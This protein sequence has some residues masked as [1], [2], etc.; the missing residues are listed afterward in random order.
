MVRF[1][2]PLIAALA[3]APISAQA[4]DVGVAAAVNQDAQAVVPGSGAKTIQLGDNVV[5]NQRIDT[6]AAGLVQI[7]LADGTAFTVGPNS[8]MTIDAFVYD[9]AANTASVAASV[10][11]GFVRFIGG[12]TSK[13]EGGVTIDTPIGT[14]GIRGAVADISLGGD[15]TDLPPHIS[16]LF[17]DQITLRPPG[18]DMQS[19][20]EAGYSIVVDGGKAS[21]Q[22]TP[23]EFVA[24]MQQVLAPKPGMSGGAAAGPTNQSA[25]R[26]GLAAS[27]SGFGTPGA[28]QSIRG[29]VGTYGDFDA[30]AAWVE[31][32]NLYGDLK[33]FF[34]SNPGY[35]D[36]DATPE[37]P[38]FMFAPVRVLTAQTYLDHNNNVVQAG[39]G[40]VA[41]RPGDEG[42]FYYGFN[43]GDGLIQFE[44]G[45]VISVP[46]KDDQ[47]YGTY[48]VTGPYAGVLHIGQNEFRA[49]LLQ[50]SGG[51]P[52]YALTGYSADAAAVLP[53]A[54]IW[55][56]RLS[57]DP[58]APIL[59]PDGVA[60]P[61]ADGLRLAQFSSG[62]VTAG[63]LFIAGTPGASD[64]AI[65]RGLQAWLAI[66]GTGVG[67]ISAINLTIGAVRDDNGPHFSG[68]RTGSERVSNGTQAMVSGDVS[69]QPSGEN[70]GGF[71]GA[72][73]ANIVIGTNNASD[74]GFGLPPGEFGTIHVGNRTEI[75]SGPA[76]Q[77]SDKTMTGFAAGV[78]DVVNVGTRT[79]RGV[80][81]LN[82]NAGE[83]TVTGTINVLASDTGGETEAAFFDQPQNTAYINDQI[84]AAT[85]SGSNSYIVSSAATGAG[86]P[87]VCTSCDYLKWGWWGIAPGEAAISGVHMGNWII[88][89]V[90]DAANMP[91]TGSATYAGDAIGTV[92]NGGAQYIATGAMNATADFAAQTGTVAVTGFDGH[93][94][95]ST[96]DST[97]S[98]F[99]GTNGNTSVSGA[100]AGPAAN[101][102]MGSFKTVDGAWSA[103][104]IFGGAQ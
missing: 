101:E 95:A 104:G 49:Y 91:M 85:R 12:R 81:E 51:N 45:R 55:R 42:A 16:L 102:I 103:S 65:G 41:V 11:K 80:V 54:D 89:D 92:L 62:Q 5:F 67:Q 22:Q 76:A 20:T 82:F 68:T 37:S 38:T 69:T 78:G 28:V 14:A 39:P 72:N 24:A 44:D 77:R 64:G 58:L 32:N 47:D 56:Y 52:V 74:S 99:A 23:P 53:T 40:I 10:T 60:I 21:V 87:T 1:T 61:F 18:G 94:F 3:L 71:F 29:Y 48:D 59:T 26:S 19:V 83:G 70:N 98:S 35:V 90:T 6:D 84:F 75:I 88:G 50:D 30:A 15:G 25:Q 66:S 4:Q 43:G 93:D 86:G 36:P 73:G 13:G 97:G 17:G 96:F 7:L 27:N 46:F 31:I 9:P 2:L 8:S 34:V 57:A 100:F 33:D 63:D 79:M